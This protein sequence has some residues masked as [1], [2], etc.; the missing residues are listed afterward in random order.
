MHV[1]A[2]EKDLVGESA[3]SVTGKVKYVQYFSEKG[4]SYYAPESGEGEAVWE[5]PDDAELA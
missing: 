2:K 1:I 3:K 4:H 5:L